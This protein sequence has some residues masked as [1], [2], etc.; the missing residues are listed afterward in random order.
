ML[1]LVPTN[2]FL[3]AKRYSRASNK[4]FEPTVAGFL[5]RL[6]PSTAQPLL[7]ELQQQM[8]HSAAGVSSAQRAARLTEVMRRAWRRRYFV[9]R[10]DNRLYWYR[11]PSV[12]SEPH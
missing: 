1:D 10:N 11:T 3:R 12:S 2:E 4:R 7:V 9:L 6:S 5:V 8:A